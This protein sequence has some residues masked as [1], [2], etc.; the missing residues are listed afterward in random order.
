MSSF[1]SSAPHSPRPV[2]PLSSSSSSVSDSSTTEPLSVGAIQVLHPVEEVAKGDDSGDVVDRSNSLEQVIFPPEI[3]WV[4]PKVISITSA[5]TIETSVADI[6]EKVPV[7]KA[8]A[9]LSFF[10]V[11]LCLPT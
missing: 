10:R 1:S 4:D 3:D 9:G 6:L 8:D 11:E 5:F 7:L 2:R